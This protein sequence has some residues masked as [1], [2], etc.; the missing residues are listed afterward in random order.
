M[1]NKIISVK[2]FGGLE[3]EMEVNESTTIQTVIDKFLDFYYEKKNL[4]GRL[5]YT[6]VHR[7]I[8]FD[9]DPLNTKRI[10]K[11]NFDKKLY[12]MFVNAERFVI[13][14]TLDFNYHKNVK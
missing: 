2:N 5:F 9:Y 6:K 4:N 11:E 3:L 7:F 1:N 13:L 8:G 12:D 14:V 10:G